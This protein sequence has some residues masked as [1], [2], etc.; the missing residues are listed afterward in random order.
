MKTISLPI[1]GTQ[2]PLFIMSE[3]PPEFFSVCNGLP[4][5]RIMGQVLG[6]VSAQRGAE[7]GCWAHAPAEGPQGLGIGEEGSRRVP[8]G[9][10]SWAVGPHLWYQDRYAP[11]AA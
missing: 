6:R 11:S 1:N 9:L 4:P 3:Q 7:V 10:A 5:Q 2:G 8:I